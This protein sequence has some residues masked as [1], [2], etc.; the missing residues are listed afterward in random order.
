MS[1]AIVENESTEGIACNTGPALPD[2]VERQ[3]RQ[4]E[5]AGIAQLARDHVA[6]YARAHQQHVLVVHASAESADH[7]FRNIFLWRDRD[8]QPAFFD[9]LPGRGTDGGNLQMAES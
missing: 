1:W 7:R 3:Q 9:G 8:R 2:E 4:R 5:Q 6:R